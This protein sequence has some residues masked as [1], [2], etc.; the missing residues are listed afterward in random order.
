MMKSKWMKWAIAATS[1]VL[2]CW[3]APW[4]LRE[5]NGVMED[6]TLLQ[7]ELE[8]HIEVR[9]GFGFLDYPCTKMI[10][11]KNT[12]TQATFEIEYDTEFPTVSIY[13]RDTMGRSIVGIE[14]FFYG[15]MLLDQE[16]LVLLPGQSE[17]EGGFYTGL[18][19][20]GKGDLGDPDYVFQGH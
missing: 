17:N 12:R 2:I 13:L 4:V 20:E 9:P 14:D 8:V 5:L 16:R 6:T 18:L 3:A 1:I 10:Q 15:M 7:N 19:E 11:L